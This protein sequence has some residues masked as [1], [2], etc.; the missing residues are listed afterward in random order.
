VVD[1]DP[2]DVT[3]PE[4]ASQLAEWFTRP[5][6]EQL[7]EKEAPVVDPE[8]EARRLV[9]QRAL[10]AVEP[11]LLAHAE[12]HRGAADSLLHFTAN[13]ELRVGTVDISA[14]DPVLLAR[15]GAIADERSVE[16]P[17]QLADDLNDCTPQALLRDL[18]RPEF[19]FAIRYETAFEPG[20]SLFAPSDS[21]RAVM[22]QRFAYR[23][24]SDRHAEAR[25]AYAEIA[26]A[27]QAPWAELPLPRRPHRDDGGEHG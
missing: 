24:T 11:A 9:Q 6:F 23:G 18:H 8:M 15:A 1:D 10:A 27:K 3:D 7:G 2:D 25:A 16:L 5:S 4:T 17:H 26:A 20:P 14:I 13:L 21:A 19:E 12:R 22:K